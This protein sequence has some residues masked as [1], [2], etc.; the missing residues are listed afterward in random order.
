MIDSRFEKRLKEDYDSGKADKIVVWVINNAIFLWLTY[1]FLE[2]S[3]LLVDILF[4]LIIITKMSW[5]FFQ[6]NV[7]NISQRSALALTF[8]RTVSID[9]DFIWYVFFIFRLIFLALWMIP[10]IL[11]VSIVEMLVSLVILLIS[12]PVLM[13][14]TTSDDFSESYLVKNLMWSYYIVKTTIIR[15]IPWARQD[16]KVNLF[17]YLDVFDD[18]IWKGISYFFSWIIFILFLGSYL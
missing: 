1:P 9:K 11:I 4:L 3:S 13:A 10:I 14:T 6:L 12:L 17:C 7:M 16:E 2:V 18:G 5:S 8:R 15:S